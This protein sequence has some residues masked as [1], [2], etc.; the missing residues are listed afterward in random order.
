MPS[1]IVVPVGFDLPNFLSVLASQGVDVSSAEVEMIVESSRNKIDAEMSVATEVIRVLNQNPIFFSLLLSAI[2]DFAYKVYKKPIVVKRTS[3]DG[4]EEFS[5]SADE[6]KS[7]KLDQT[8]SDQRIEVL[9]K[10]S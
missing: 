5:G 4:V 9:P 6:L 8:I 1:T 2:F 3:A 7:L 10:N